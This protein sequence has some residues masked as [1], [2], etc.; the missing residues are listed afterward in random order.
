[1]RQ[2]T[3]DAACVAAGALITR[4]YLDKPLFAETMFWVAMGGIFAIIIAKALIDAVRDRL[5]H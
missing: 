4:L 2:F 3:R 5:G 1:M